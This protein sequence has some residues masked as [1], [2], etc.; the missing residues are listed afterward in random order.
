MTLVPDMEKEEEYNRGWRAGLGASAVD[1]VVKCDGGTT[2]HPVAIRR[3]GDEC[4]PNCMFI[5]SYG[6]DATGTCTLFKQALMHSGHYG[7][8]RVDMKYKACESCRNT[9]RT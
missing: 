1:A 3:K 5:K 6:V 9:T 8:E 2:V 7:G 4:D